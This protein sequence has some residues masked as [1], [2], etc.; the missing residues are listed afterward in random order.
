MALSSY[1][2]TFILDALLQNLSYVKPSRVHV[3]THGQSAA[4]FGLAYLLGIEPIPIGTEDAELLGRLGNG[5]AALQILALSTDR[6][7][8]CALHPHS[9]NNPSTQHLQFRWVYAAWY[10]KCCF[11]VTHA[12]TVHTLVSA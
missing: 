8:V 12:V 1:Q 5:S 10:K 6:A 3:D 2:A 9:P 11:R 7:A 4:V